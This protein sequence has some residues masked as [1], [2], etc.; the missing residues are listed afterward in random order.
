M[1]LSKMCIRDRY[2]SCLDWE[3]EIPRDDVGTLFQIIERLEDGNKT[4]R[5]SLRTIYERINICLLY[6]SRCV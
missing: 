1:I 2:V 6:T 5:E 4:K 3:N